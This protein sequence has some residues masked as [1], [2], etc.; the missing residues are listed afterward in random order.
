VGI[1]Q[2]I[3]PRLHIAS[4]CWYLFPGLEEANFG[5]DHANILGTLLYIMHLT[6]SAVNNVS[7]SDK[8]LTDVREVL[9][10]KEQQAWRQDKVGQHAI[11]HFFSSE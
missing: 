5:T 11:S 6:S 4:G 2:F 10:G 3:R 1:I 9:I 8:E 7:L